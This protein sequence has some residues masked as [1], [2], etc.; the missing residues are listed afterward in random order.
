MTFGS[1]FAGIEG[2]GLGMKR[3]GLRCQWQVENCK[4][5]NK[6]LRHHWPDV[7]RHKN[8]VTVK[9]LPDVD[10]IT[11]GFP[12]QD[13][14]VAGRRGGIEAKRSGLFFQVIR[15]VRSM[16]RASGNR[17]PE[18]LVLE[19]VPGLFSS[20]GGRDF[21]L[22]LRKLGESGALDIAWAVLDSQWF[23][24]AQR[25]KR[26]FI[27]ADFRGE[28]AGEI[29]SVPYG[30]PWDSPPS[31]AAREGVA[32]TIERRS[33]SGFPETDGACDGHIA[34]TLQARDGSVNGH[35]S[36][37][38]QDTTLVAYRTSG[39]KTAALNCATDPTQNIITEPNNGNNLRRLQRQP[40][41]R[42]S[43]SRREGDGEGRTDT[44]TLPV[45]AMPVGKELLAQ[46]GSGDRGGRHVEAGDVAG[47]AS[48]VRRL[49]PTECER[50][51]G[52]PDGWTEGHSDS[53][54]YRML[55]NAVSVP[56]AEWIGR[57]IMEAEL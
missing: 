49:T 32:G 26:V 29:L 20:N 10:V 17:Y 57:R 12:C 50:L 18:F 30:L 27:V 2:F 45:Q 52:F 1:L 55:G 14:S 9:R 16:R 47:T 24:L 25:R 22:V 37:R 5:C 35:W 3:A 39:D 23:G 48:G 34:A 40:A 15:I 4:S 53:A 7:K 21:A 44:E 46:H 41:V 56:V 38:P 43:V 33:G 36:G 8:V 6:V 42:T 31:R 51:Q 13:L 28:R 19:N 54:R 11:A